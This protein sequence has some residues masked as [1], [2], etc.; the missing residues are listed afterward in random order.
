MS[1]RARR[2]H[3]AAQKGVFH[4][5]GGG[6][7]FLAEML[8]TPGASRTVLDVR[9]PY[10]ETALQQLLGKLQAGACSDATARALAMSAYMQA[11]RLS[12][13]ASFGLGCTASL[14]TDR[15]KKGAHRAHVALQTEFATHALELHFSADRA[16]EEAALADA[17]WRFT[18]I[19]LGD[20][21]PA[22]TRSTA[23][24]SA[25]HAL[26]TG[27]KKAWMNGI[28]D[29]RLLVPGSFNP[30]HEGH[31]K[32]IRIA[33]DRTGLKAALE[34]SIGNVDKAPL[35]YQEIATRTS[36]AKEI[37]DRPLWLTHAPTFVEKAALFP[38]ATFVVGADTV[39]RI[40]EVR[41]Y[42]DK[43]ARDDA[44]DFLSEQ[45]VRFLVFGRLMGD[46]F[47]TLESLG[48]P[49][50]LARLCDGIAETEFRSDVS[51]TQIRDVS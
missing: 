40:A 14:A 3:D 51:S 37:L 25:W 38:N 7:L 6:S 39:A 5:T 36:Q 10:A 22:D 4:I 17:L 2:L 32:M 47:R 16:A 24:D 20:P 23:G 45:N 46:R 43:D 49:V 18:G 8:S 1:E 13:V 31:S 9:V 48:L 41:Y 29:G 21:A 35:D 34:L 27:E 15:E 11:R 33:E 42:A 12:G 19:L 26:I 28:H 44:L 50:A 30:L